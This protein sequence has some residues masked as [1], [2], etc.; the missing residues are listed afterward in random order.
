[1]ANKLSKEDRK[2]FGV[3][4]VPTPAT[5]ILVG[6]M[7]HD[8]GCKARKLIIINDHAGTFVA[9]NTYSGNLGRNYDAEGMTHPLPA[10]GDDRWKKWEKK[11]YFSKSNADLELS[12]DVADHPALQLIDAKTGKPVV[13]KA[14]A[15][16]G[17]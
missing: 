8:F 17:A 7:S 15:P 13:A 4:G 5:R 16:A 12:V 9:G 1:M 6:E 3:T 11:G 14:P 10:K 2:R